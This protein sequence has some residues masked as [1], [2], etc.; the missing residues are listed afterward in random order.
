MKP[1]R[2]TDWEMFDGPVLALSSILDYVPTKD[3]LRLTGQLTGVLGTL[4]KVMGLARV[5]AAHEAASLIERMTKRKT[6]QPVRLQNRDRSTAASIAQVHSIAKNPDPDLLGFSKTATDGAPIVFADYD[7]LK[8]P[9]A[10]LGRKATITFMKDMSKVPVRYAVVPSAQVMVSHDANGAVVPGYD[11]P[12]AP[13]GMLRAVAGNGRAAGIKLAYDRGS[14]GGYVAGLIEDAG[15]LQIDPDVIEAMEAPMLVRIMRHE[16]VSADIGDKTN[17]SGTA[18]FSAVEQAKNDAERVDLAALQFNE[19]GTPTMDALTRFVNG[20]PLAERAVLAPDGRPTTQALDRLMAATFSLA[21]QDDELVK[22]YSQSL[23][24]EIKNVLFGMAQA[25]GDMAALKSA[26]QY[27]IRGFVTQAAG[28]ASNAKRSGLP[29]SRMAEQRDMGMPEAVNDIAAML[30]RNARSAKRIADALRKLARAALEAHEAPDED[31]YGPVEK[32]P[33]EDVVRAAMAE[34]PQAPGL[35]DSVAQSPMER[36]RAARDLTAKVEALSAAKGLERLRLAKKVREL[37]GVKPKVENEKPVIAKT[38]SGMLSEAGTQGIWLGRLVQP[39]GSPPIEIKAVRWPNPNYGGFGFEAWY[40][41]KK[42]WSAPF[43]RL[44]GGE[45]VKEMTEIVVDYFDENGT[46]DFRM[47]Q[48]G[49]KHSQLVEKRATAEQRKLDSEMDAMRKIRGDKSA[50]PWDAV[51]LQTKREIDRLKEKRYKTANDEKMLNLLEM[52]LKGNPDKWNIGD[53]AS[54]QVSAGSAGMQ[55]NRGFRVVAKNDAEKT[56]RLRSVADTG[57]TVSGGDRDRIGDIVMQVGELKRERKYDAPTIEVQKDPPKVDT[58]A[59]PVQEAAKSEQVADK[60]LP[61]K[62]SAQLQEAHRALGRDVT[63]SQVQRMRDLVAR[64]VETGTTN[65]GGVTG[66][67]NA[68]GMADRRAQ[69]QRLDADIALFAEAEKMQAAQPK[70]WPEAKAAQEAA[71]ARVKVASAAMDKYPKS[72]MGLTP[73][74]VKAS[75][76][77]RAD[78][79]EMDAAMLELQKANSV[80]AKNFAKE[81][82]AE[83]DA[84]RAAKLQEVRTRTATIEV[85]ADGR[86]TLMRSEADGRQLTPVHFDDMAEAQRER[87]NWERG[88]NAQDLPV[89]SAESDLDL[90]ASNGY[91]HGKSGAPKT[92]SFEANEE[93]LMAYNIGYRRGVEERIAVPAPVQPQAETPENALRSVIT[94]AH[95]VASGYFGRDIISPQIQNDW[96]RLLDAASQKDTAKLKALEEKYRKDEELEG[97]GAGTSG[98]GPG[99]VRQSRRGAGQIPRFAREIRKLIEAANKPQAEPVLTAP[100]RADIEAQQARAE[101]AARDKAKADRDAEAREVKARELADIKRRSEAAAAS[102]VLGGDAMANLSGQRGAFDRVRSR[103]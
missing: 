12:E 91:K 17:S 61:P 8:L 48:L 14:A 40:Q 41:G 74:A 26:G 60:P 22:L 76:Q 65:N 45:S 16:D 49:E 24:P 59:A 53:G 63:R 97:M 3:F 4:P 77:W 37:L 27:D 36:M 47:D 29:L 50:K 9:D 67:L 81:S 62:L 13:K 57:L 103:V 33:P 34:A 2:P 83:R 98:A 64:E 73:D 86:I 92:P 102:F 96:Q 7:E 71:S 23:D 43:P 46:G 55:T 19:D 89:F 70:T 5:R 58:S 56:V 100:T 68:K 87:I 88:T 11:A 38:L 69:L 95:R 10:Q 44:T 39:E 6:L 15:L 54:Y 84:R 42:Q 75:P 52:R 18:A 21:Y 32:Q 90:A 79:A 82:A 28:M 51:D 94:V 99:K 20:M 35:L 85:G 72:S 66:K 101:Q 78:K 93:K 80:V 25:A 30:A 31:L 1:T